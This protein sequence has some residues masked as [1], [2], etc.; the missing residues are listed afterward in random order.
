[1][2]ISQRLRQRDRTPVTRTGG[3][4]ISLAP[5]R[6][7]RIEVCDRGI[8]HKRERLAKGEGCVIVLP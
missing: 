2:G 7:A 1:M 8:R 4:M 5:A 3:H 6:I